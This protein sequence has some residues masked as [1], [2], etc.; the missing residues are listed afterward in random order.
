MP[1]KPKVRQKKIGK[2]TYWYTEAGGETDFGNVTQV[3]SRDPQALFAKH[4]K[5]IAHGNPKNNALTC[6]E[7][8][9]L[10]LD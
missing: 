7:L 8:I 5:N 4:L 3:S 6:S 1:R 9:E 2:S 10:F